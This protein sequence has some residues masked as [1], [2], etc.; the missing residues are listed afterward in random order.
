M[1]LGPSLNM[2]SPAEGITNHTFHTLDENV[3]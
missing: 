2:E 3:H 1:Q